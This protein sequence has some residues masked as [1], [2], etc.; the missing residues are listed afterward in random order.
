[1]LLLKEG[2]MQRAEGV[3]WQ[4]RL[5]PPVMLSTKS[6]ITSCL[7]RVNGWLISCR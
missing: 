3:W 1:M 2:Y 6:T 4:V 5:L 7:E